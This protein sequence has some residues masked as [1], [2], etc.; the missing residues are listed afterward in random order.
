MKKLDKKAKEL[1]NYIQQMLEKVTSAQKSTCLNSPSSELSLQEL[2][3]IG[4]L[5]ERGPAIMRDIAGYL[6]LA[7]STGT[8]I[9]D[10]LVERGF[11]T[12]ERNEEDRRVVTVDL[13]DAGREMYSIYQERNMGL[14]FSMLES[15]TEKEQDTLLSLM[16]KIVRN[17]SGASKS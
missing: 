15:L 2:K 3:V 4:L 9:V 10:K 5:G 8:G 11:V 6:G 1:N 13:T 17:I 16:R 7:M 12:R 14:S